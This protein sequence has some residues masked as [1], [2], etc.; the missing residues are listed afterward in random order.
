VYKWNKKVSFL[1]S[2]GGA[3]TGYAA[4]VD[5]FFHTSMG[6]EYTRNWGKNPG[7]HVVSWRELEGKAPLDRVE[8]AAW[9]LVVGLSAG[10]QYYGGYLM[11]RGIS[12][13]D[14]FTSQFSHVLGSI[15]IVLLSIGLFLLW[16]D[17]LGMLIAA[18]TGE[19]I[20]LQPVLASEG[21]GNIF[22]LEAFALLFLALAGFIV[23]GVGWLLQAGLRKA[24]ELLLG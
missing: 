2:L 15:G 13:Q 17:V 3:V 5:V 18:F 22:L 21:L 11:W 4:M 10:F 24:P 12:G 19:D 8:K 23:Y 16:Y 7:E 14:V 20:L 6:G 9:A 1:F